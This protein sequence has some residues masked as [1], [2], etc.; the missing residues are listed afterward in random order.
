MLETFEECIDDELNE[1]LRKVV[2][3]LIDKKLQPTSSEQSKWP[4]K[5]IEYFNTRWKVIVDCNRE[6]EDVLEDNSFEGRCMPENELEG[7]DGCLQPSN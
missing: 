4:D 7:L 3:Q 5:M 2:N 1:D 6:E